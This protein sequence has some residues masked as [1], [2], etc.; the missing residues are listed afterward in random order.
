MRLI[1]TIIFLL[2]I[3]CSNNKVVNNHGNNALDLKEKKIIVTTS[4]RNDVLN[5]MGR[6]SS[7]SLFNDNSWFYFERETINQSIFK[8]GKTKIEKNYILEVNFNNSGIVKSK[9]LYD[10]DDMNDI[11]AIKETTKKKYDNN[12]KF[13]KLLKSMEQKINSPKR[14]LKK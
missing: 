8:L 11:K 3:S 14:N 7:V 10:M 13:G 9:K 5:L 6:P 1:L 2:T 12:S 4:N